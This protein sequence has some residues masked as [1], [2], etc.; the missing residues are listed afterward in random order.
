LECIFDSLSNGI[1]INGKDFNNDDLTLSQALEPL[2]SNLISTLE[3]IQSRSEFIMCDAIRK[4]T[5][6][7]TGKRVAFGFLVEEKLKSNGIFYD[8]TAKSSQVIILNEH[9]SKRLEDSQKN[10]TL[11][12]QTLPDLKSKL[13]RGKE[14]LLEETDG[15]IKRDLRV[16][17]L[18]EKKNFSKSLK[19]HNRASQNFNIAMKISAAQ[20]IERGF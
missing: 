2:N 3:M 6:L 8:S 7:S 16:L 11:I 20:N 9:L 13:E 4:R 12:I 19:S 14:A 5:E 15:K 10:L 18:M 1:Q 17:E